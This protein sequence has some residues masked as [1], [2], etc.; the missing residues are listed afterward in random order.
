[1]VKWDI[2][3]VAGKDKVGCGSSKLENFVYLGGG[4]GGGGRGREQYKGQ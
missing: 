1:M 3:D 4:G 2:L